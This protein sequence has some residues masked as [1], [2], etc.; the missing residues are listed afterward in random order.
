M[1]ELLQVRNLVKRFESGGGWLGGPRQTVRAVND[2]SF[3]VARGQSLGLVG[4]SGCG[5]STVARTLLRLIE[6][7]EGSI[8]FDGHDI[9]QASASALRAL[10]QRIQIVFQDPYAS[11]NPRRTVRQA[12]S[13]PLRVHRR[14][15][16]AQIDAKVEQTIQEVGLPLS[17]LDRY[18]HEFSGGQ[19]QRIGIARALVLDPEL[20]VADEP[21]SALD[22]SV[23]A[24][25]LQLLERLKRDRGLSFV[26]VSHDLGVVRHFCD[27]V[28]VMYL[29]RI[30]ERGPTAQVLDQPRHPY[31]RVL[32]DSSPVPDPQARIRLA[33]IEGEIPA[34]THLPPGCTFHPR[35]ARAQADC[36]QRVPAL[37]Q[38]GDRAAACFHPLAPGDTVV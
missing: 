17:A 3:S 33:K 25:I 21:V 34:P 32:R 2:V 8:V 10:R 37:A 6:P 9:R 24:Q 14:G 28:C 7:D 36:K 11:L 13:E 27:T 23:Q 20:I 38:D 15:T 30:I 12:L 29:G 26:F 35:C 16:A 1:S 18:P 22:V 4:E 19:R 31:S 5:K